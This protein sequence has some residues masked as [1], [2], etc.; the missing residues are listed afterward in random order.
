M[1]GP[2]MERSIWCPPSPSSAVGWDG[3]V[4]REVTEAIAAELGENIGPG[5]LAQLLEAVGC[6]TTA[7]RIRAA[8]SSPTL[9]GELREGLQRL[10]AFLEAT[11]RAPDRIPTPP[12]HLPRSLFGR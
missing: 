3:Q 1:G 6:D 11:G 10:L 2:P 9:P 7:E 5:R 12:D 8:S 4:V